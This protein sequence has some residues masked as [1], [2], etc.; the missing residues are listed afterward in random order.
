[1]TSIAKV[2]G[3]EQKYDKT[4]TNLTKSDNFITGQSSKIVDIYYII[5]GAS[6][7]WDSS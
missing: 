1:M 7:I 5:T 2:F 3:T 4:L 6:Q